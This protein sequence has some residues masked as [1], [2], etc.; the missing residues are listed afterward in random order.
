MHSIIFTDD[1]FALSLNIT[2]NWISYLLLLHHLN[3]TCHQNELI[4]HIVY[5]VFPEVIMVQEFVSFFH[6]FGELCWQNLWKPNTA[7]SLVSKW[8][9]TC[10]N[11]TII[12]LDLYFI[13]FFDEFEQIFKVNLSVLNIFFLA[14]KINFR[15]K[16]LAL[17]EI[18]L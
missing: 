17:K 5:T 18:F 14:S 11:L 4:W 15:K 9:K 8:T 10:P 12:T 3:T 2:L 6:L 13:V 16:R 1:D 7:I